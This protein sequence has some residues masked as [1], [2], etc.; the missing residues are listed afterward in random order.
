[1]SRIILYFVFLLLLS[2]CGQ[3][4]KSV[5]KANS[6]ILFEE[7]KPIQEQLNPNIQINLSKLVK[8][9]SFVNNITNNNGNINFE[10]TFEKKKTFKFSRIKQFNSIDTEILFIQ[11]ND[12]IYFDNKGTIFRINENFEILWKVN[13]Y[14][15]KERKLN[16]ILYFN[17][18]D[19]RLLVVDTL[20]NIFSIN[21]ENGQ[22]IWK[23]ESMTPFNSNVAVQV[24][25]FITVDF[26]NVI[27]CFSII[28]GNELWNFKTENTFIKSQ[29]KLS[30]IIKDDIV[31]SL[32]NLGDLTALNVN[33]GSLVWQTPTQSN[34]I[35]LN[36]FSLKNSEMILNNETIYFS[37]NKNELFSID[38]TTG[39][40][41][42]KQT[43]NSSL[44]PTISENYIF[45]ISE[46]GYL[47]VI[48]TETGNIIRITDVFSNFKKREKVKPVGFVIAKNKIYLSTDNGR[49]LIINLTN[50]ETE[51][52]IKINNEKIS[53]P[54]INNANIFL[55][56]NNGIIRSN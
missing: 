17:Y 53:R 24:D 19:N 46:E 23:T 3:R 36:A 12:L 52:V 51:N 39:I 41:K 43:V 44:K 37:N 6:K 9:N 38:S 1:M 4:D 31:Y 11:N 35:F 26:D 7:I 2:S 49:I 55:I 10:P 22:L 56:K 33:D 16:P 5:E 13:H 45:N 34:E 28:D 32:N 48:D 30:V 20:S 21:L 42:W 47:F 29:K 14:S 8:D 40:V 15:K 50:S 27:R 25:K 18:I 54:F